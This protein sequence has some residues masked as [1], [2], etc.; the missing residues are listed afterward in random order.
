MAARASSDP[1]LTAGCRA[2]Y[3]I[4]SILSQITQIKL[5]HTFGVDIH[6]S[7]K[8]QGGTGLDGLP[9]SVAYSSG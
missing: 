6:S 5:S 8:T 4:T 7:A 2:F 9:P 3:H 1:S